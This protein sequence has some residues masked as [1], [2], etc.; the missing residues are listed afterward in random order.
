MNRVGSPVSSFLVVEKV[1]KQP[2]RLQSMLSGSKSKYAD[3]LRTFATIALGVVD[4]LAAGV[5]TATEAVSYFFHAEN[6]LFVKT[7]LKN[8]L[9]SQI[10]GRG[11][12]LPDLSEA[13][14]PEAAFQEYQ[15]ELA[16]IRSLTLT[17]LTPRQPA[18][19]R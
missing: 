16:G 17:L 11:V 8:R 14:A 2:L 5:T 3:D 6:C 4:S 15:R 1:M 7:R 9:A 13:L 12:Q 10:M 19:V 18:R